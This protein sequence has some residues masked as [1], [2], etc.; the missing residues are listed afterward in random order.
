M[1]KVEN[2]KIIFFIKFCQLFLLY[3]RVS[4][5]SKNCIFRLYGERRDEKCKLKTRKISTCYKKKK[6]KKEDKNK[7]FDN[8]KRVCVDKKKEIEEII[9]NLLFFNSKNVN[10]SILT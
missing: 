9:N 6:K 7:T 5:E 2:D 10:L 8:N 1:F 4:V 3:F